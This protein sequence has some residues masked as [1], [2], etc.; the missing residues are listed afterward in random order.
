[1]HWLFYNPKFYPR[2]VKNLPEGPV[3]ESRR[4]FRV[5][6]GVSR[7]MDSFSRI[8]PRQNTP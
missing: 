2:N 6:T 4:D 7:K 8:I 5:F 1:M 3:L